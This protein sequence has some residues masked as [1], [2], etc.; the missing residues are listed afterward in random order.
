M[1]YRKDHYYTYEEIKMLLSAW[2]QGYPSLLKVSSIGKTYEGR[3]I[4]A[5]EMTAG[6]NPERK[7]GILINGNLHSKE[8]IGSNA[9]LYA[10]EYFLSGYGEDSSVKKLLEAKT[11]YFIPRINA[12]GAEISVATPY[13]RRGSKRMFHE[14][15]EG[16]YPADINGDG[17]IVKMRIPSGSGQWKCDEIDSRLMVPRTEDD[18][19]SVFYDLVT[20][21]LVCGEVTRPLKDARDPY[22]LDPN[23]EFPFDWS[24]DTIGYTRRECSG[25]YPLY[26]CEVRHLADFIFAHENINMVVDEHSC[27]GAYIA[28]MTF[29][30]EHGGPEK[31]VEIFV[32]EG[33]KAT[34]RTGYVSN[35]AFPPGLV[36]VAKGSYTTWLYYERGIAAWCNENWNSRQLVEPVDADHPLPYMT[37]L[38]PPED[39][40][41]LERKLLAWDDTQK[42]SY[43][44]PWTE[45]EHP[46]LGKVEI[47]GWKEKWIMDN[48]P[49]FLMEQEC[50]K[51]LQFILQCIEASPQLSMGIP[52][53]VLHEGKR[54]IE[55]RIENTGKYPV[56]GTYQAEKLGISAEITADIYFEA[57]CCSAENLPENLAGG[58]VVVLRF[59]VPET[60]SGPYRIELCSRCSGTVSVSG[61]I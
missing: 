22:D 39:A 40:L 23:R 15:E 6:G 2:Q 60:V 36:G 42:E 24:K 47:G 16:V 45:F 52:A 13:T 34:E 31:D 9:V 17:E 51:A 56:S 5:A 28:P 27:G 35:G 18:K 11:L 32:R 49:T 20:E 50:E 53:E 4:F 25:K 46:Q 7:P 29:C 58:E 19:E 44:C 14:E 33:V 3:E 54:Y 21:G 48:P 10:M 43:F 12:D 41:A 55:V 57:D 1:L 30:Q 37:A 26:E 61:R 59:A 8:L 38:T